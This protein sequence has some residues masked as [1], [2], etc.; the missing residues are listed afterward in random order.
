MA[1]LLA[2]V[3]GGAWFLRD[4]STGEERVGP[5]S[6]MDEAPA[7]DPRVANARAQSTLASLSESAPKQAEEFPAVQA[8][9]EPSFAVQQVDEV[10]VL[11][12][13][14]GNLTQQIEAANYELLSMSEGVLGC[15][16]GRRSVRSRDDEGG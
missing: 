2:M 6:P 15:L 7:S 16:L 3:V 1:L 13:Q 14:I 8:P 4:R 12:L 9:A 10:L 11:T 5:T